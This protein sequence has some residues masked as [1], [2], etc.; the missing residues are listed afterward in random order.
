MTERYA[1][2]GGAVGK[3]RLD[4]IAGFLRP[5]TLALLRRVGVRSGQHC[6]DVGCGGGHV[7]NDLARMVAPSGTALG[8][9]IDPAVLEL[10]RADAV[11]GGVRCVEFAVGDARELDRE[12]FD[13]VYAR[14]LLGHLPDPPDVVRRMVRAAVPGGVVVVEDIDHDGVLTYPPSPAYERYNRLFR[15]LATSRGANP[16]I[17]FALPGLLRDAGLAEIGLRVTHPAFLAGVPKYVH[18]TTMEAISA[19]VVEDGLLDEEQVR[20]LLAQMTEV[21]DDPRSIVTGP[22]VVQSWGRRPVDGAA[23]GSPTRG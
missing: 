12:G 14:C 15:D 8:I 2:P 7:T 9:D 3:R 16:R 22:R 17:G 11:A 21:A 18:C 20:A 10:A 1:L 4:L 19:A 6:L 23:P 13:V 5:E